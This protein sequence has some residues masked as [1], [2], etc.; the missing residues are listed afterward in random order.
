MGWEGAL[1][2]RSEKTDMICCD[3]TRA[4]AR[5]GGEVEECEI[6]TMRCRFDSSKDRL[7]RIDPDRGGDGNTG[8]KNKRDRRIRLSWQPPPP[9]IML[10]RH[11]EGDQTCTKPGLGVMPAMQ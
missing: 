11:G 1:K 6:N 3:G 7:E 5:T 10:L 8:S 9:I 2:C 4:R